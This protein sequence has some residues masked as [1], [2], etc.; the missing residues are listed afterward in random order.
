MILSRKRFEAKQGDGST[1]VRVV[2]NSVPCP[3]NSEESAHVFKEFIRQ[4]HNNPDLYSCS[5]ASQPES[6]VMKHDGDKWIATFA[7]IYYEKEPS[8]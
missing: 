3:A 7:A 6:M 4:I 5:P 2:F 1:L 8:T